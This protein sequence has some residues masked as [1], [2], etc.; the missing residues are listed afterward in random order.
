MSAMEGT[1]S[2][3]GESMDVSTPIDNH[4]TSK[5][6]ASPS[7]AVK[8]ILYHAHTFYPFTC[9]N[10]K[11][12]VLPPPPPQF[13]ACSPLFLAQHW[14]YHPKTVSRCCEEYQQR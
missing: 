6:V 4:P 14:I 12:V 7:K 3:M 1:S 10:L 8:S 9:D 11:D 5:F 13:S 2:D